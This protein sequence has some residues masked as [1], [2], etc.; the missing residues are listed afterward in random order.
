MAPTEHNWTP[1]AI[2]ALRGAL[3]LSRRAFG[4]RIGADERSIR[5]WEKGQTAP[6]RIYREAMD[7]EADGLRDERGIELVAHGERYG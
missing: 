1:A 5:R 6:L 2:I 4:E 3:E 7:I